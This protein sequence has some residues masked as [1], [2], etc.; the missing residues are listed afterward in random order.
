MRGVKKLAWKL[1]KE[2]KVKRSSDVEHAIQFDV[3]DKIVR[4]FAKP[5][6]TLISCSCENHSRYPN[7]GPICKHKLAALYKWMLEEN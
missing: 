5:G 3:N 4:I 6:R 7:E 2:K 1:L